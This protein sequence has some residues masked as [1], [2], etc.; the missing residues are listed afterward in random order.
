MESYATMQPFIKEHFF[1]KQGLSDQTESPI[2]FK[3]KSCNIQLRDT[4][5]RNNHFP[6]FA[7]KLGRCSKCL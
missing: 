3:R 5:R 6:L 7:E 1:R 2:P 4:F